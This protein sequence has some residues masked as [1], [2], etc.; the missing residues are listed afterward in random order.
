MDI[1]SGPMGSDP[2]FLIALNGTIIFTA[3][4]DNSGHELWRSDG[5]GLG[6][7]MVRDIFPGP[8]SSNPCN[9]VV[10]KG[11]VY[12]QADDGMYVA[13]LDVWD[14]QSLSNLCGPPAP[15]ISCSLFSSAPSP[16]SCHDRCSFLSGPFVCVHDA[17]VLCT[18][19]VPS[20][21][22]LTAPLLALGC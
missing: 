16:C 15:F 10:Y 14:T 22:C 12:F 7:T 6:T 13:A 18:D 1:R 19:M 20:C 3:Y 9:Y 5:T 11:L 4:V 21:G 8:S 17:H 2:R